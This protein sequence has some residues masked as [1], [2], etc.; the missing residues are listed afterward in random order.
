M[1][2]YIPSTDSVS[3]NLNP[4]RDSVIQG[5][6]ERRIAF[7]SLPLRPNDPPY[8]AWGLWGDDDECGALNLLTPEVAKKALAEA[9][10]GLVIPL[11]YGSTFRISCGLVLMD[12]AV[13]RSMHCC[14][15]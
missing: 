13:L 10:N 5:S 1:T 4:K 8:S 9:E 11:K 12:E 2:A 3:R 6:S 7:E 15:R 14:G